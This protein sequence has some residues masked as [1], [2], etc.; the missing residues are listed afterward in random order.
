MQKGVGAALTP[1]TVRAR[2]IA[3]VGRTQTWVS[4]PHFI[5][6]HHKLARHMTSSRGNSRV[7]VI[8]IGIH[9]HKKEASHDDGIAG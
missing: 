1:P 7:L 2:F 3:P 4:Y 5:F 6:K 9:R 8:N